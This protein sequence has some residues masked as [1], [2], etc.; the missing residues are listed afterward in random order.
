MLHL[1]QLQTLWITIQEKN[2]VRSAPAN[3]ALTKISD[4]NHN[5]RTTNRDLRSKGE[6]NEAQRRTKFGRTMM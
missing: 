2:S 6:R 5:A 4:Q 3:T 1:Q